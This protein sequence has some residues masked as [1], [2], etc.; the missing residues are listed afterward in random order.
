MENKIFNI[1]EDVLLPYV[2][3]KTSYIK[4]KILSFDKEIANCVDEKEI[5]H[6]SLIEDLKKFGIIYFR[7]VNSKKNVVHLQ[8]ETKTS[9]S[10]TYFEFTQQF[11]TEES[12]INFIVSAKY[13]DGYVCPKC[14][15]VELAVK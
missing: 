1:N 2:F 13:K 12:A 8:C 5:K 3:N 15:C 14:G 7:L 9:K 6:W 11:P 10:M 4:V